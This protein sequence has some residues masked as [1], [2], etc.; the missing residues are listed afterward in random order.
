[1]RKV[2]NILI[3]FSLLFVVQS[4]AFALGQNPFDKEAITIYPNP[5][6][7]EANISLDKD[8]NLYENELSIY[9]FN[10][11]GEMIHEIES[12]QSHD[13]TVNKE[14][15]RRSGIYL[16]QLKMN[17]EVLKTGKINIH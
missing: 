12:I 8:L 9:F 7:Y 13:F 14:L 5:V 15:F 17:G 10:V 4:S 16:F 11:V 2:Y 1:L 3:L 6:V